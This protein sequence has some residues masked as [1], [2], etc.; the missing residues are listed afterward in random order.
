MNELVP[1]PPEFS[2]AP[3]IAAPT[4][5]LSGAQKAAIIL[6]LVEPADA[7][8]ILQDLSEEAVVSFARAV[9]E[10]KPITAETLNGVIM[11]FLLALGE[12][13]DIRGGIEQV[14]SYLGQFMEDDAVNQIID[15]LIDQNNRPVWDR[16]GEAPV[17]ATAGFLALEHPQTVSV[18]LSKL[19][20]DKGAQILELL[21]QELAQNVVMRMARV[22]TIDPS[23]LKIAE[24]TV[25]SHFLS[26]IQRQSNAVKPA[27]LIGNLMNNIGSEAR[28]GF[29][30]FLEESDA[31]LASE[32]ARV[33]FTFADIASRLPTIAVASI[34]KDVEEERL[35]MALRHAR[36]T[37][38]PS[39]DFIMSNLSK[40]MSERL[41]E[42]LD[43]MEQPKEKEAEAAQ[44][45]VVNLIQSKAKMGE[46][47][48]Y[49]PEVE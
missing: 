12:G 49:E 13:T 1:N 19:R 30:A 23:T 46:F 17:D 39:Y 26:A 43:A 44:M 34:V 16:F 4:G 40:R 47:T 2:G 25:S 35:L 32:V 33:M 7:A 42:D 41:A 38:N 5:P 3:V 10:L 20:A 6:S 29:L 9:S 27:E 45:E 28:D 31:S 36:D 48:L 21:D 11:E 37:E 15:D 18:I 14:R 22:P 24:E 8:E